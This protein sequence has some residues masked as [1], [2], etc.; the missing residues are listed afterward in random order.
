MENQRRP[1]VYLL[2]FFLKGLSLRSLGSLPLA[3]LPA[4]RSDV[5]C[6]QSWAAQSVSNPVDV[7]DWK[8][9][10]CFLEMRR[11]RLLVFLKG[12]RLSKSFWD[13][14]RTWQRADVLGFPGDHKVY[15]M[16]AR[17]KACDF[18][19]HQSIL[20]VASRWRQNV[21]REND[22][23]TNRSKTTVWIMILP[24]HKTKRWTFNDARNNSNNLAIRLHRSLL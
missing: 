20:Q 1:Q 5:P 7:D 10:R 23:K 16:R 24:V 14:W 2:H 19:S 15:P 22:N 17:T 18:K 4:K 3:Q 12:T 8:P 11:Q 13:F 21:S 9:I 6:A